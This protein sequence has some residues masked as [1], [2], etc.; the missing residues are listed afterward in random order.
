MQCLFWINSPRDDQR[1]FFQINGAVIHSTA[2]VLAN[3][4]VTI[5]S[6][7]LPE[8]LNFSASIPAPKLRPMTNFHVQPHITPQREYTFE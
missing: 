3:S 8:V 2:I 1:D 7:L 6:Y 5:R 4:K